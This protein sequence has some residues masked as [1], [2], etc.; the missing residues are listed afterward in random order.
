MLQLSVLVVKVFG[1]RGV[2][3]GG[4][5]S[6]LELSIGIVSITDNAMAGLGATDGR[7][8]T[9]KKVRPPHWR[10]RSPLFALTLFF[11][12]LFPVSHTTDLY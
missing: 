12:F 5:G 9:G 2:R 6:A 10:H 11:H 4:G 3:G 1:I 8:Y 7:K